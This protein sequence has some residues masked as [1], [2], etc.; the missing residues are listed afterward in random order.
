MQ[1]W[2]YLHTGDFEITVELTTTKWPA[3]SLLEGHWM[4]NR[5]AMVAYLQQVHKGI[6]GKITDVTGNALTDVKLYVNNRTV[7]VNNDE[8]GEY[9]R[10]LVPD[11]YSITAVKEG[12]HNVTQS[13]TVNTGDATILDFVMLVTS[14]STG[15]FPISNRVLL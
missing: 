3:G 11:T 1:D 8:F 13:V 12:Y 5:E 4:D 10:L 2:N 14:A 6:R 15:M 7:S 9:Y